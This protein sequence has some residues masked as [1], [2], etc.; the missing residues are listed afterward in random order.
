MKG[1]WERH[2]LPWQQKFFDDQMYF[3]LDYSFEKF[4]SNLA[5]IG[6]ESDQLNFTKLAF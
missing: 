2:L 1:A 3:I 6:P 4:Q 5:L